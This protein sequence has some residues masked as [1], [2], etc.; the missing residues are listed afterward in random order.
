MLCIRKNNKKEPV[1]CEYQEG[2]EFL[3]SPLTGTIIEE[4]KKPFIKN[5]IGTNPITK[6]IEIIE[7]VDDEKYSDAITDYL[8]QEWKGIGDDQEN[9]LACNL[10]NKKAVMDVADISNFIFE[11]AKKIPTLSAKK[12]NEELGN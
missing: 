3:V 12:V 6:E 1:W 4:I 8:I 2:V 10:E 5:S 7:K 11:S 9:I